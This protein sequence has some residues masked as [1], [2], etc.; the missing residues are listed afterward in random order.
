MSEYYFCLMDILQMSYFVFFKQKT[1]YE[2]ET[3]LEFRRVLFRSPAEDRP[4]PEADRGR[5][6]RPLRALRAADRE[7]PHQGPPVRRSVHQGR[8][9]TSAPVARWSARLGAALRCCSAP[10]PPRTSSIG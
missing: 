6:L 7:G 5:K 8:A 4:G 3:L 1:A 9:G 10:R 2:I